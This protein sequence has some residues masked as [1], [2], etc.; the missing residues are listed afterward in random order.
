MRKLA[1]V[2][3]LLLV[4]T[5]VACQSYR[6]FGTEPADDVPPRAAANSKARGGSL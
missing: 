3:W 5:T 4:V 1:C 6:P 2:A